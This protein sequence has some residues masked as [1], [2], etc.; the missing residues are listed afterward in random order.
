[1]EI[2]AG[3]GAVLRHSLAVLLAAALLFFV[4]PITVAQLLPR[5]GGAATV[6]VGCLLFFQLVVLA[7]YAYAHLVAL[8]LAPRVQALLHVGLLALSAGLAWLARNFAAP[9]DSTPLAALLLLLTVRLALPMM[10]LAGTG[11]LVQHWFGLQHRHPYRLYVT[12]N[13]AAV[14]V[15]LGFPLGLE[16]LLDLSEAQV[17]WIA[18]VALTAVLCFVSRPPGAQGGARD[19]AAEMPFRYDAENWVPWLLLSGLGSLLLMSATNVLTH[20][21]APVP[22]VSLG[23]L[24][25]YLVS[26]AISFAPGTWRAPPL[27]VPA[28]LLALSALLADRLGF[29]APGLT[30][31]LGLYAGALF[32][33][34]LA[35]HGELAARKPEPGRLTEFYLAVATGSVL[36]SLAVNFLAPALF[37]RYLEFELTLAA[38]AILALVQATRISRAAG[39]GA[40]LA[41]LLVLLSAFVVPAPD[42]ERGAL[43]HAQR[44]FYGRLEVRVRHVDRA[45][46][47]HVLIHD[48][49]VH[50]LQLTQARYQPVPTTYY[51]VQ[52]GI[53]LVLFRDA[54]H[55]PRRVGV[56]G[57]G[58]GTLATY[59]HEGDQI[60][61]LEIDPAMEFVA[62]R[63]FSFLRNARAEVR[64][65]GGDARRTL[66]AQRVASAP[67]YDVLVVDAFNGGAIPAHLL[68]EEAWRLYWERLTPDGVLALHLSNHFVDL[69]PVVVH[70]ARVDPRGRIG[71]VKT[72]DDPSWGGIAASWLIVTRD[73]AVW[74]RP[75]LRTRALAPAD[76]VPVRWSDERAPVTPLLV[77]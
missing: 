24:S 6:W 59:G 13:V 19:E 41:L 77:W 5:F 64:V 20:E 54:A 14:V 17:L 37:E 65:L 57:L 55:A 25:L 10:L 74:T 8:R 73:E 68:T 47:H 21:I 30:E 76:V 62:K 56:V 75:G 4:Q 34:F 38:V 16:P 66:E 71:I 46:E 58:T 70:H 12:S 1:M 63:F 23:P 43:L 33:V 44:G 22:L 36:G 51:G 18:G 26:F 29:L 67:R 50:G 42:R 2:R 69:L 31:R 39:I 3:R 53:G 32:L 28:L 48:G 45:G 9:P 7:G 11:P 40:A 61:F 15:L 72:D 27:L 52:T 49:I 35:V 60:D